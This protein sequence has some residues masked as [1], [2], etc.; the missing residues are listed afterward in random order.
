[1]KAKLP[2]GK[3][4]EPFSYEGCYVCVRLVDDSMFGGKAWKIYSRWLDNAENGWRWPMDDWAKM[5]LPRINNSAV[6]HPDHMPYEYRGI[7]DASRMSPFLKESHKN[8]CY[9]NGGYNIPKPYQQHA[10]QQQDML[11]EWEHDLGIKI[12]LET[13]SNPYNLTF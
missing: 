2:Y 7:P 9:K 10:D 4:L 5:I 6:H 11:N 1:M 12:N 8:S 3:F 13:N